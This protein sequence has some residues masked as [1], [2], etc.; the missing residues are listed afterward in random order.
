MTPED[1]RK[2]MIGDEW[3]ARLQEKL[4]RTED[5]IDRSRARI[6]DHA[7]MMERIARNSPGLYALSRDL[8]I[9]LEAGWQF[10]KDRRAMLVRELRYIERR[11]AVEL[12]RL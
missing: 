2:C 10:L 1:A 6:A 9:N 7:A 3:R 12:D 11:K 4:R 8:H 5:L